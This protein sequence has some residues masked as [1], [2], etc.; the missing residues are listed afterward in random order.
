MRMISI[1]LFMLFLFTQCSKEERPIVNTV[2]LSPAKELVDSLLA[3]KK[4]RQI[5]LHINMVRPAYYIF[6][7]YAGEKPMTP[8]PALWHAVTKSG[9]VAIYEDE[10]G[11][12][13][14]RLLSKDRHIDEQSVRR[15][16]FYLIKIYALRPHRER[17]TS[18]SIQKVDSR[19]RSPF[20][21]VEPYITD[22]ELKENP[23]STI[24]ERNVVH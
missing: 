7:L 5:E 18:I 11:L 12:L 21:T 15:G 19:V 1:V 14:S 6:L 17:P 2:L 22:E 10:K 3:G 20:R 16:D 24:G 13:K 4:Y 23:L 9:T 8:R